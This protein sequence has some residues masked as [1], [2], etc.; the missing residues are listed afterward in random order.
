MSVL[1]RLTSVAH[2]DGLVQSRPQSSL[3]VLSG[4][5]SPARRSSSSQAFSP[6]QPASSSSNLPSNPLQQKLSRAAAGLSA[7]SSSSRDLAGLAGLSRRGSVRP[8]PTDSQDRRAS[9]PTP[10]PSS[11]PTPAPRPLVTTRPPRPSSTLS[12]TTSAG[13]PRPSAISTGRIPT[14]P[15][16]S[17]STHSRLSRPSSVASN[18]EGEDDRPSSRTSQ[19]QLLAEQTTEGRR[20][21]ASIRT[22]EAQEETSDPIEELQ[23]TPKASTVAEPRRYGRGLAQSLI[24]KQSARKEATN[25]ATNNS[26]NNNDARADGPSDQS[27]PAD[28]FRAA[29]SQRAA[30]SIP[31]NI[32]VGT[33]Q[34]VPSNETNNPAGPDRGGEVSKPVARQIEEMANKIRRFEARRVEDAER[35]KSLEL[36]VGEGDRQA[37]DLQKL[38][39][40]SC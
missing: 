26:N 35:I 3:S 1:I 22:L 30:S 6:S 20:S 36:K 24:A 8:A 15:G 39:S 19:S 29:R 4:N 17:A 40:R 31:E 9:S 37:E 14:R 13:L 25:N 5:A 18:I 16:S 10:S 21:A 38:T 32:L 23:A 2:S 27:D 33:I 12:Q 7:S 11:T 34:S 28:F